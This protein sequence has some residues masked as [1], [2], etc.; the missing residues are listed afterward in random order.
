MFLSKHDIYRPLVFYDM[1]IR[2]PAPKEVQKYIEQNEV[3]PRSG[4]HCR[5]EGGNCIT[6]T[7]NKYLKSHLVPGVPKYHHWVAASRNHS[8]LTSD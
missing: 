1:K 7:E 8:L 6:E 5:G 3:F 2:A 4:D